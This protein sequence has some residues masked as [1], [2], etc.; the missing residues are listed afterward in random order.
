MQLNCFNATLRV[1]VS[2]LYYSTDNTNTNVNIFWT[3]TIGIIIAMHRYLDR[4]MQSS[5][6]ACLAWYCATLLAWNL[7][8]YTEKKLNLK[9]E[10]KETLYYY[11]HL[12]LHSLLSPW[13]EMQVKTF[14]LVGTIINTK[15]FVLQRSHF[16][17]IHDD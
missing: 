7:F 12:N 3:Y 15:L 14:R 4:Y 16:V 2:V 8:S 10:K 6:Q 5:P 9:K 1:R 17:T 13:C 11:N